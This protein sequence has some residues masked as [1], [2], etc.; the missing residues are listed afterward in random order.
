MFDLLGFQLARD[1]GKDQPFAKVFSPLGVEVDL[2]EAADGFVQVG[3]K[4]S[5]VRTVMSVCMTA[6]VENRMES[7]EAKSL[8]GVVRFLREG[9]FGRCGAR[10]LRELQEHGKRSSKVLTPKLKGSLKWLSA[11]ITSSPPSPCGLLH[12]VAADL[13]VH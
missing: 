12:F 6:V 3:P 4:K 13:R 7:K 8:S 2:T 11:F 9:C 10:P 1:N 5:R